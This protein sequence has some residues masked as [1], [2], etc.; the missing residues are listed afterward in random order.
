MKNLI[1]YD[2]FVWESLME[3]LMSRL[4]IIRQESKTEDQFI[5][6]AK[7]EFPEMKKMADADRFLKEIWA[8]AAVMNEI[9]VEDR[10]RIDQ[11]LDTI[12]A[13]IRDSRLI[14]QIQQFIAMN[15]TDPYTDWKEIL[16]L[17]DGRFGSELKSRGVQLAIENLETIDENTKA[18]SIAILNN[19]DVV[20]LSQIN[21]KA[22]ISSIGKGK[23]DGDKKDDE[24]GGKRVSIAVKN[25]QAAQTEIIAEKA[26]GMAIGTM[27]NTTPT[28]IGG[29]LGSIISSDNFIMDGHHRWAATF[30]C[31]PNAK[32]Q[33]VQIDLPGKVLVTALNTITVGMF[34][35]EGNPGFGNIEE[36]TS[37]NIGK[38][39]DGYL[40]TGISGKFP[41]TPEQ[42]RESLGNMP[43]ANGDF[44]KGKALMMKNADALP[45]KIMP[46]A[47]PRI[48]M[49]VIGPD[50]VEKVKQMLAKGEIDLTDPY[51]KE[52]NR[53]L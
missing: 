33:A 29:D 20:P 28:K 53:E 36:F 15:V 48:E 13:K 46:G 12:K 44:E 35:R 47:P 37:K 39:I 4:D 51:S 49:P 1:T 2:E 41:I 22:A 40:E 23:S 31:D 5:R 8:M 18:N 30:L 45:K 7:V 38:L 50:E 42:V 34:N 6:R 43:G 16:S 9:R 52:V 27:L 24:I 17:V 26:I 3:S 19:R 11:M 25:L 14:S 10:K 32:V 21:K